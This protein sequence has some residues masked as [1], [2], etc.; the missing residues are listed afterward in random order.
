MGVTSL[1]LIAPYIYCSPA[2]AAVALLLCLLRAC[3]SFVFDL[4]FDFSYSL[5]L[6]LCW[7]LS[8]TTNLLAAPRVFFFY[9][10]KGEKIKEIGK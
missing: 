7:R 5:S 4:I 6:T 2:A 9:Y 10:F 3:K 1:A 8:E